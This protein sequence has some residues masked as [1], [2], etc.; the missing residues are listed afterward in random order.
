[1]IAKYHT[2]LVADSSGF[3]IDRKIPFEVEIN[4]EEVTVN[5]VKV[6]CNKDSKQ[7][8]TKQDDT[9]QSQDVT[10]Q[11]DHHD[12]TK[13]SN[14]SP[15]DTFAG[16]GA[17]KDADTKDIN[18]KRKRQSIVD[19][20]IQE[21]EDKEF[22]YTKDKVNEDSDLF[23]PKG[24]ITKKSKT[25]RHNKTFVMTESMLSSKSVRG[26]NVDVIIHSNDN[27]LCEQTKEKLSSLCEP[28][29]NNDF[30]VWVLKKSELTVTK[31]KEIQ[32]L[33][34]EVIDLLD[35]IMLSF[36]VNY[37]DV[38]KA[39][40]EC[41]LLEY[42]KMI[43]FCENVYASETKNENVRSLNKKVRRRINTTL[44]TAVLGLR[45]NSTMNVSERIVSFL[46]HTAVELAEASHDFD[47]LDCLKK[48]L[49]FY[50]FSDTANY[51]SPEAFENAARGIIDVVSESKQNHNSIESTPIKGRSSFVM[52]E[53]G[54]KESF[55]F[56]YESDDIILAF[57]NLLQSAETME[58]ILTACKECDL[59]KL[60][61]IVYNKVFFAVMKRL[62]L[63]NVKLKIRRYRSILLTNSIV[64]V[65]I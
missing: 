39:G 47:L 56:C 36:W 34:S 32:L 21:G 4:Q 51:L 54:N 58:Y 8:A 42:T 29:N 27:D 33:T 53:C 59:L 19:S 13:N 3:Y 48:S 52:T 44:R 64:C 14:Q 6:A 12:D 31:V 15:S 35:S 62:L 16:P 37:F 55:S 10:K 40:K 50:M 43:Q 28:G 63:I 11:D 20:I 41:F 61:Q 23:I 18:K 7:D 9:K 57:N 30:S 1:M 49:D 17:N 25:R 45:E 46:V 24:S 60:K 5:V 38:I 26:V 2:E 65:H 22:V